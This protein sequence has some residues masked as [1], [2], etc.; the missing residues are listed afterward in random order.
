[1]TADSFSSTRTTQ[2][3]MHQVAHD[4]DFIFPQTKMNSDS[5]DDIDKTLA[6]LTDLLK[7]KQSLLHEREQELEKK[8]AALERDKSFLIDKSP[9]DVLHLNIGGTVIAVLRRT[10]TSV[11]DSMLAS[12]FSGRWDDMLEK[13]RGGNF[14]IDQPIELFL[15]MCNYL[16]A[17]SC[18]T[19]LGP[20]VKSPHLT[21]YDQRQDFYRMVEYFGMTLG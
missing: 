15:P 21:C 8:S 13:D 14:F 6:D 16:R 1:V 10:L 19:P 3:I 12:R 18:E 9:C 20:P 5:M 2:K 11:E 7:R 17:K 4:F